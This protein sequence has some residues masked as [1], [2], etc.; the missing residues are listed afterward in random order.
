MLNFVKFHLKKNKRVQGIPD[1]P[2]LPTPKCTTERIPVPKSPKPEKPPLRTPEPP[3]EPKFIPPGTGGP[4]PN[5]CGSTGGGFPGPSPGG[6]VTIPLPSPEVP[7]L[8]LDPAPG[9]R[10]E[11]KVRCVF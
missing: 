3:R 8:D 2:N 6:G 11:L 10:F 5:P 7:G 9:D 4:T 1:P